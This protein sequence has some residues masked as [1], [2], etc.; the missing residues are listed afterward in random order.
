MPQRRRPRHPDPYVGE[1]GPQ[2][3]DGAADGLDGVPISHEAALSAIRCLHEDEEE[4]LVLGE[5]TARVGG[6]ALAERQQRSSR[7]SIW[8]RA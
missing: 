4:T 2:A 7:R 6:R 5:E 1:G 8:R 3:I